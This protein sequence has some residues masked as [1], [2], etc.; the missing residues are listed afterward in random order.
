MA[1]KG[2]LFFLGSS[3]AKKFGKI[4]F[5]GHYVSLP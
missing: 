4:K 2:K 3:N 1:D 5:S